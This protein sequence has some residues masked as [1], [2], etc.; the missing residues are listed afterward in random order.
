MACQ[1][2]VKDGDSQ[3]LC[4]RLAERCIPFVNYSGLSKIDGA[5]GNGPSIP[6]PAHLS[7]LVAKVAELLA[8]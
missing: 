2:P 4:Q 8:A 6:K 7:F 5:C 3:A 1:R